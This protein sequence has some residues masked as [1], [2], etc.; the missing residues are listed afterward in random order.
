[1]LSPTQ[2]TQHGNDNKAF[3]EHYAGRA[4]MFLLFAC[5]IQKGAFGVT[6]KQFLK[7]H[8]KP[9]ADI[10]LTSNLQID[11]FNQEPHNTR[12]TNRHNII[13]KY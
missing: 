4:W 2:R 9:A 6:Q 3:Q 11:G 12:F 13:A 7:R 5:C 8:C 10:I 1:M